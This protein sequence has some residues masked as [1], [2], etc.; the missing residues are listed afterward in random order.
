MQKIFLFVALGDIA[1]F[2][3]TFFA[4]F[5]F[6]IVFELAAA[7]VKNGLLFL[8]TL[9][10]ARPSGFFAVS[11]F[12]VFSASQLAVDL[13]SSYYLS[14]AIYKESEALGREPQENI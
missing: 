10:L 3:V 12:I 14:Y 11:A 1:L 8:Q 9:C 13:L 2:W 4:R 5:S 7:L 6:L